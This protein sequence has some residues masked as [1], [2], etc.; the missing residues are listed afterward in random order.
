MVVVVHVHVR[1]GTPTFGQ[2]FDEL[3]GCL[4][5]SGAVM[6]PAGLVDPPSSGLAGD[7]PEQKEQAG[8][9]FPERIAFEVQEDVSVVGF[10]KGF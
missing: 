5:F 9:R 3:A 7:E 8:V 6:S 10:G 1:V 4:L 2:E